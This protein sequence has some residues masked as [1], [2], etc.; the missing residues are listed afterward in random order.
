MKFDKSKII[1]YA[2]AGLLS[3]CVI[4]GSGI[5]FKEKNVDHVNEYC[6]LNEILGIEHQI[7]KINEQVSNEYR[8]Y[9]VEHGKVELHSDFI[10]ENGK[11]FLPA[12]YVLEDDY[13]VKTVN[14]PGPDDAV[15]ITKSSI[16]SDEN[17]NC[18]YY[19]PE[20][21]KVLYNTKSR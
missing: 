15:I 8:A 2:G 17:D 7:K 5:Y 20:I 6:L 11:T 19:N 14:V 3:V 9:A 16:I 1:K 13:G 4:A 21:V 10:T 18:I 12:G